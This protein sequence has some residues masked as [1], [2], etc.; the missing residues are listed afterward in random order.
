MVQPL[1]VTFEVF[2]PWNLQRSEELIGLEKDLS[3]MSSVGAE[4]YLRPAVSST[5]A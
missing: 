2:R 3:S 5:E 4:A 1:K